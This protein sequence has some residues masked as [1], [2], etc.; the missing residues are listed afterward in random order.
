MLKCKNDFF[1]V[2]NRKLTLKSVFSLKRVQFSLTESQIKN[3]QKNK[4]PKSFTEFKKELKLSIDKNNE[5][6]IISILTHL[7]NYLTKTQQTNFQTLD[8]FF[9]CEILELF[10]E[11]FERKNKIIE[12][13]SFLL[14]VT[15][16]LSNISVGN[17]TQLKHIFNFNV[18]SLIDFCLEFENKDVTH[19]VFWFL[20]NSSPFNIELSENLKNFGTWKKIFD[21]FRKFNFDLSILKVFSWFCFMNFSSQ[22]SDSDVVK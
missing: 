22:K 8:D 17:T 7:S 10:F 9:E 5:S 3:P 16:I 4:K 13:I 21:N 12:E 19:N 1:L 6:C 14:P 2:E 11:L 18:F 15:H 20:A